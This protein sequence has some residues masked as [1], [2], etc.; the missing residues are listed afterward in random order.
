[1][2]RDWRGSLVVVTLVTLCLLTGPLTAVGVQAQTD[3]AFEAE[4]RRLYDDEAQFEQLSGAARSLL[5]RKFG[6]KSGPAA[7]PPPVPTGS[8]VS[9]TPLAPATVFV[10]NPAADATAQDTQSGTAVI[11]FGSTVVSTFNDS[12]SCLPG[13][14][15]TTSKFTGYARSTDGGATFTDLGALPTTTGGDSGDPVLARDNTTGTL[16][17]ATLRFTGTGIQCWRSTDNGLTWVTPPANCGPGSSGFQD[18]PWIAVDNFVGTGQ[19]N[20]YAAWRDFGG[21]PGIRFARSTDGGV[22]WTPT[23][24]LQLG[25]GGQ[26]PNVVVGTDHSVYVFSWQPGTP[27]LILVRKSTDRGATFAAAV[28]V[29]SDL[30]TTGVNGDLGLAGG[31]RTNSFPQ[32]AVNPVSGHLYVTYNIIAGSSTQDTDIRLR[33]STDGGATWTSSIAP[34]SNSR[35]DWS[36]SIAVDPGSSQRIMMSWYQKPSC[37]SS[38][39]PPVTTGNIINR[40]GT[41][42]DGVTFAEIGGALADFSITTAPFPIVVNQDPVLLSTYMGDYD[43]P[44]ADSGFFYQTWGD[45]LGASSAHARQPDVRFSKFYVN[46]AAGTTLAAVLPLSRSVQV[47]GAQAT[48]FAVMLNTGSAVA[49]GC[50]PVPPSSPPANLG[51]FTFQTTTPANVL[52]GSP[53]VSA[54]I[55]P[56]ALQNFVFGFTPTGPIPETSLAMRFICSNVA[57]APQTPGVNNFFIVA[58]TVPVPDTIALMA[59]I[60]GDGVVRIASSSSTQLFAIGTSNVGATGMIVVSG[61]TGGVVLP[62][63]LTVCE[64]TGGPV[65]L[66]PP[67]PT[68]T[69][70]YLAGQNRSFAFFAQASGSIPFDP[71]NNRVFPRLKQ[72]GVLRG[73]TSAA[74]C[75][76]S[77]AGC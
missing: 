9:G 2:K 28:T 17:L 63:T 43:Q 8:E 52:S 51:T 11:A 49:A 21:T 40:M 56:G 10:N 59:T 62:L 39:C 27:Q 7:G 75:T 65:C 57:D 36:P 13:C 61:D 34:G 15:T 24:G 58:D 6:R 37:T 23:P 71:A 66:A 38:P 64:T 5:E 60:S 46:A 14:G 26:G 45:N 53:G 25:A 3:P 33:R 18:K 69:V 19:G 35:T 32:A 73:A 12:G 44:A 67:T 77:N 76:M 16:Y 55:A 31:I 30:N 68:V 4:L 29:A 22:T 20:V 72:A 70:T 1:M 54:S 50:R 42:V 48:A 41:F 74:V 47:G